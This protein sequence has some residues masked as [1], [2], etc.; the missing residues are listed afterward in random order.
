MES[1]YFH[2]LPFFVWVVRG[3]GLGARPLWCTISGTV[4]GTNCGAVPDPSDA[5][6]PVPSELGCQTPL[7]Y[8]L[9]YLLRPLWRTFCTIVLVCHNRSGQVISISNNKCLYNVSYFE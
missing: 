8:L 3:V 9:L 1:N 7:M 6:S 2:H 5:P 4:S